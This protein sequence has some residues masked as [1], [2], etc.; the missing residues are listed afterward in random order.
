MGYVA[1]IR[2]I[3]PAR[4]ETSTATSGTGF[5]VYCIAEKGREESG[6][7]KVGIAAHVDKRLSS[8]QGG[9]WRRLVLCWTVRLS[10]RELALDAEQHCLLSCR[11]S[12]YSDDTRRQLRSEW[13]DVSPSKA[14]EAVARMVT[15]ATGDA[16]KRVS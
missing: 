7:C 10:S 3:K 13:V 1:R 9:N 14:F 5:W 6:P 2:S 16:V 15:A 8:L 4:W 11:P 12:D